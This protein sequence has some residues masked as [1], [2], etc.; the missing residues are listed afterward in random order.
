MPAHRI[1]AVVSKCLLGFALGGILSPSLFSQTSIN[2]IHVSPRSTT[3]AIESTTNAGPLVA[4]SRLP[5][6]KSDVR[7]VLVPVSVTD[8]MS[9][10]VTGLRKDNFEVF[11]GKQ[12]QEIQ[13]FSSEDV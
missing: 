11:E 4:E 3:P 10:F 2:D 13:S 6:L 7:L 12:P 1:V 9:R 8:P 5:V